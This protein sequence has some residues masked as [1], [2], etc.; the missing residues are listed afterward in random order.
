[1]ATR[2]AGYIEPRACLQD[3][4]KNIRHQDIVLGTARSNDFGSRL[5]KLY[6]DTG[7]VYS[8]LVHNLLLLT[9]YNANCSLFYFNVNLHFVL[10]T[11]PNVDIFTYKVSHLTR[12]PRRYRAAAAVGYELFI[13]RKSRRHASR[14]IYV[15]F[16]DVISAVSNYQMRW[17]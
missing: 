15:L 11:W 9:C 4:K 17:E 10:M 5:R 7:T 14:W 13:T 16:N 1:M 8:S 12:N 2:K 3:V 6:F